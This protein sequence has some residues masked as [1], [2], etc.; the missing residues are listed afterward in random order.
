MDEKCDSDYH[1]DW[2]S[3]SDLDFFANHFFD[4]HLDP[5]PDRQPHSR[6]YEFRDPD[7]NLDGYLFYNPF[8]HTHLDLL[9]NT[10]GYPYS[11]LYTDLFYDTYGLGNFFLDWNLDEYSN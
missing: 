6:S 11:Q 2:V 3:H 10:H 4:T 1:L 7:I 8:F 9:L 5:Q